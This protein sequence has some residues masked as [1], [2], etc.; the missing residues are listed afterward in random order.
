M[1]K[2]LL[3]EWN[4]IL[5]IQMGRY[6]IPSYLDLWQCSGKFCKWVLLGVQAT[7]G[8]QYAVVYIYS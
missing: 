2:L 4:S 5:M 7:F 6:V 8:V 3:L 1:A